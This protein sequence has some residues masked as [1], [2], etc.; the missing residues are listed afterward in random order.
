M[1]RI[2]Y[3][4]E[5]IMKSAEAHAKTTSSTEVKETVAQVAENP[6][7][8]VNGISYIVESEA[9]TMKNIIEQSQLLK[10]K[11]LKIEIENPDKE[12]LDPTR[13]SICIPN[14]DLIGRINKY[15]KSIFVDYDTCEISAVPNPQVPGSFIL[16]TLLLFSPKPE[17]ITEDDPRFHNLIEIGNSDKAPTNPIARQ[18]S[19]I[20]ARAT[21]RH[22][23]FNEATKQVLE[24]FIPDNPAYY[25]NKNGKMVIDWAKHDAGIAKPNLTEDRIQKLNQGNV[26]QVVQN[27]VTYE[28]VIAV[29]LN[30]IVP[31]IITLSESKS[32][33]IIFTS[34]AAMIP[35]TIQTAYGAAFDIRIEEVDINLDKNEYARHGLGYTAQSN[36]AFGSNIR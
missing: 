36:W 3:D 15:F 2:N 18:A 33:K 26:A 35:G 13:M 7:E 12:V 27:T 10:A 11:G 22:F 17:K 21:G 6:L 20:A 9:E 34:Y 14:Y 24:K 8:E 29:D 28:Y 19:S 25:V 23:K 4:A 32:P 1:A 5:A 16:N 31:E 30:K